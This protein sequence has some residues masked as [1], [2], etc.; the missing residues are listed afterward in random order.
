MPFALF[1]SY[2]FVTIFQCLQDGLHGVF[3]LLRKHHCDVSHLPG[4]EPTD[5][6]LVLT[7]VHVVWSV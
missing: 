6:E 2:E 5:D 3:L 7:E 1:N 4:G